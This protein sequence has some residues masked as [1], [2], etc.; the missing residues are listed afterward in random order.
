[1]STTEK[2]REI[3][4]KTNDEHLE[5]LFGL[6]RLVQYDRYKDKADSMHGWAR[7]SE[8]W[9][10]K[11]IKKAI[12]AK[13]RGDTKDREMSTK[14]A[15]LARRHRKADKNKASEIMKKRQERI[16]AGKEVVW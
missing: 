12:A 5:E 3:I 6:E 7:R 1:M 8:N 15:L 13:R 11:E 10:K 14:T 9:R 16:K 2:L 4:H